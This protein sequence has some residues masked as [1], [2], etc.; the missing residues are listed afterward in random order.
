MKQA[1]SD[2]AFPKAVSYTRLDCLLSDNPEA[3]EPHRAMQRKRTFS[4]D[5]LSW[6][7]PGSSTIQWYRTAWL[8]HAVLVCSMV[9][10]CV[11]NNPHSRYA[12]DFLVFAFVH[13]ILTMCFLR[14]FVDRK[15]IPIQASLAGTNCL[16]GFL[17]VMAHSRDDPEAIVC[18]GEES[19]VTGICPSKVRQWQGFLHSSVV[20]LSCAHRPCAIS[21]LL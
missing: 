16:R 19:T 6:P 1:S 17:D 7:S 9:L 3:N 14:P 18:C 8:C 2:A 13:Q 4:N 12:L 15:Y 11:A 5:P 10:I 20:V 21:E